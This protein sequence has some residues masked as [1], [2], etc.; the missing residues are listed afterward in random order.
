MDNADKLKKAY[1]SYVKKYDLPSYE[2]LD[3][4]FELLYVPSITEIKFPLRFIRRRL[5]DKVAWM[6]NMLQTILQPNPSSLVSLQ[7]S[8]FFDNGSKRKIAEFL[9]ELMK[10]ERESL[11]IEIIPDEKRDADFIKD[12]YSKWKDIKNQVA[13]VSKKLRDGWTQEKKSE[14]NHYF[15]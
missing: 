5:T 14:K 15:G 9:R 1:E 3:S 12:F 4:E 7:E 6:V 2:E 8:N 13:D 11:M 10:L